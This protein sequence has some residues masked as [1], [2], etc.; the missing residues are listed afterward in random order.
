MYVHHIDVVKLFVSQV[1]KLVN[2]MAVTIAVFDTIKNNHHLIMFSQPHLQTDID[3]QCRQPFL[4]SYLKETTNYN[5]G[6]K[7]L[8]LG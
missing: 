7:L 8:A 5:K 1:V 3:C 6:M 2:N 4:S